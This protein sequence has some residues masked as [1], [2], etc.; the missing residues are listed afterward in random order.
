MNRLK[1]SLCYLCGAMDRVEDGGAG[2]RENI[3]PKLKEM[4]VERVTLFADPG[5][6]SFYERQG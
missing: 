3:T 1:N 2:W 6:I 4:G 5:V